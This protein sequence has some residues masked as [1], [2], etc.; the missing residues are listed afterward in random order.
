MGVK[1]LRKSEAKRLKDSFVALC[2]VGLAWNWFAYAI[3]ARWISRDKTGK[4][5]ATFVDQLIG[6]N[7]DA[8]F[9]IAAIY[10]GFISVSLLLMQAVRG[11]KNGA[12][13]DHDA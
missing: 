1:Q 9:E 7:Y 13:Q 12:D 5:V 4:T 11:D 3:K 10:C 2:A 6:L 8:I